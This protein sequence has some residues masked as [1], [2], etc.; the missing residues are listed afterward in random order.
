MNK[1]VL[2]TGASYVY[3]KNWIKQI[4]PKYD[5]INL[6]RT[7]A[8]NKF[9]SDSV[10][11]TI[12]LSDPPDFVFIVWSSPTFIDLQLP[13]TDTTK[14]VLQRHRLYGI[15]NDIGY[16]FS[17]GNRFT[18]LPKNYK[19]IRSESW[20]DVETVDDFINLPGNIQHECYND[21]LFWYD[22]MSADGK[23]QNFSMLQYMN[24]R[25]YQEDLSFNHIVACCNFLDHHKIP[26]RFTFVE[27]PFGKRYKSFGKLSKTHKLFDRI[28]WRNYIAQTPYE[29]GVDKDLLEDKDNY[30]L[31]NDGY[32]RWAKSISNQFLE[33]EPSL[34]A[35]WL[36]K[37]ANFVQE[38]KRSRLLKD[39]DPYIYK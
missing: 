12:D 35:N 30:H 9:I 6:S 36:Q 26:Y 17:G 25:A 10:V 11:N 39:Q 28:K 5:V 1:K 16:W 18:E 14:L 34:V 13:L 8:G 19:N 31:T 33:A 7:A 2:V 27:N 29:Y 23:I 4:F 3:G 20:P 38:K 22:P 24:N 37:I 32:D 21:N 15:I